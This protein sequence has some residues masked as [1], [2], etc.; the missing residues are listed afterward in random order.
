MSVDW[1][2]NCFIL[3]LISAFGLFIAQNK[4]ALIFYIS[5]VQIFMRYLDLL[6]KLRWGKNTDSSVG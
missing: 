5:L 1:Y 3:Y 4:I 2:K 6:I